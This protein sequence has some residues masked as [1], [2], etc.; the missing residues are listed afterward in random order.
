MSELYLKHNKS[1]IIHIAYDGPYHGRYDLYCGREA[2]AIN[3]KM[4]FPWDHYEDEFCSKCVNKYKNKF[5]NLP[6]WKE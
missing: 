2:S 5:R 3:C 4:V 1:D 6:G